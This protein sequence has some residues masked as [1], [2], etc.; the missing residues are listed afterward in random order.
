MIPICFIP[1]YEIISQISGQGSISAR[2]RSDLVIQ[3]PVVYYFKSKKLNLKASLKLNIHEKTIRKLMKSGSVYS[4][5]FIAFNPRLFNYI[6]YKFL[7][8]WQRSPFNVI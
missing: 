3:S 2:L 6:L 8:I 1:Q 4:A 7:I 5:G